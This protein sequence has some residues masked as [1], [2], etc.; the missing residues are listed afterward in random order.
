MVTAMMITIT[1]IG[2]VVFGGVTRVVVDGTMAVAIVGLLT[3]TD[4]F[5]SAE[6]VLFFD[7]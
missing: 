2:V 3:T 6:A 7:I 4:I 5:R 1:M